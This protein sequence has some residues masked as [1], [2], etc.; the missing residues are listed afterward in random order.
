MLTALYRSKLES[1]TPPRRIGDKQD[2]CSQMNKNSGNGA[3]LQRPYANSIDDVRRCG[4]IERNE[5][6]RRQIES[7]QDDFHLPRPDPRISVR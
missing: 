6:F 1:T 7:R 4:Q 5:R 3:M 2:T